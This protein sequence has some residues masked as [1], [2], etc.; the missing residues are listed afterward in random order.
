[1]ASVRALYKRAQQLDTDQAAALALQQTKEDYL[2][3]NQKQLYAGFDGKGHHLN[4][5]RNNKYARVKNEMNPL[6]GLG[7]PDFY[8]TGNFYAGWRVETNGEVIKTNLGDTQV[9]EKLIQRDPE[10]VGLSGEFKQEYVNILQPVY[11]AE[12]RKSLRV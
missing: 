11:I 7:N 12:I 1:M 4:R 10:I 2:K 3:E 6:P 5:Y 9:A 8:V